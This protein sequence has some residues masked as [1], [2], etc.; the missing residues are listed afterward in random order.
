MLK[1]YSVDLNICG[2]SILYTM[3]SHLDFTHPRAKLGS[4][5]PNT[6]YSYL[7]T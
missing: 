1:Y 5:V 2:L 3:V 6:A 7:L 4:Y